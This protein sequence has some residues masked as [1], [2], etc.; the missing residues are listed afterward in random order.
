MF[1]RRLTEFTNSAAFIS[2][3][4]RLIIGFGGSKNSADQD[5]WRRLRSTS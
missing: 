2:L 1:F 3:F 4:F 5:I